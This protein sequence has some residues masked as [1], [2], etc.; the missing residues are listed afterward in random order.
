[1]VDYGTNYLKSS[2]SS[3]N[4]DDLLRGGQRKRRSSSTP[5][6]Y[7]AAE[8]QQNDLPKEI[9]IGEGNEIG[10]RHNKELIPGHTY[11][12][13]CKSYVKQ[14]TGYISKSSN[15]T[16]A[17]T[18]DSK[19]VTKDTDD[20]NV[21]ARTGKTGMNNAKSKESDS[22][23]NGV[24]IAGVVTALVLVIAVIVLGVCLKR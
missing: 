22:K 9:I 11:R 8:L 21:E 17:V 23:G 4:P 12:F 6:A 15:M 14:I 13:F 2:I 19:P 16:T 5:K 3:N 7:I 1:M 18:L 20:N 10:G 24:L